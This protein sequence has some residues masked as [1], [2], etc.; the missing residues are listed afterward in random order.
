MKTKQQKL[1]SG[2]G[3]TL[4]ELLVVI[5]IIAI[6]AG[7]LLP[8]LTRAKDKANTVSCLNNLRQW[9][10][11]QTMYV[12]DSNQSFPRTKIPTGTTGTGGSYNEDYP[13]WV[14]LTGVEFYNNTSGTSNGR[15]AWFNVL[16]SLVGKKPLWQ[17]AISSTGP[18]DFI[19]SKSIFLCPT[20]AAR[21]LDS[22][23]TSVPGSMDSQY[24]QFNYGMNSKGTD[25]LPTNTILK[26]SM[27]TKPSAFVL[28]SDVRMRA[29]ETPY[30]GTD[31]VKQQKVC[32]PQCYT[33]RFS[34]RH[35]AGGQITFSDGHAARFRYDYVCTPIGGVPADPGRPDINWSCDGHVVAP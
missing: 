4:I 3:F 13:Y 11:A 21:G 22:A 32:S 16:P 12:D 30:Y 25:G 34:S 33:S 24:V 7:M 14:D 15:D 35:Q 17:Y 2:S 19:T 26:T 20:G 1:D 6:L 18:H 29:D 9:G 5:A 31:A 28:F 27:V 10:M 23:R 8:A